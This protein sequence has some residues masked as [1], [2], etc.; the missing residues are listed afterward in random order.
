LTRA[1]QARA[2]AY[3]RPRIASPAGITTSAGP[4]STSIAMPTSS[5]VKPI[6]LTAI[7]LAQR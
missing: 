6:T 4:G 7:R 2:Q 5:T 1:S 3:S